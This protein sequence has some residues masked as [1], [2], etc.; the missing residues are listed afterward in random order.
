[1]FDRANHVRGVVLVSAA[2]CYLAAS[3]F[4]DVSGTHPTSSKA[5]TVTA[6]VPAFDQAQINRLIKQL[7]SDKFEDHEA[8]QTALVEIGLPARRALQSAASASDV[9]VARRA[10]QSLED[11]ARVALDDLAKRLSEATANTW[12]INRKERAAGL[13]PE[14]GAN[15]TTWYGLASPYIIFPFPQDQDGQ[16][17]VALFLKNVNVRF[18]TIADDDNWTVLATDSREPA[19]TDKILT[20]MGLTERQSAR[21]QRLRQSSANV[22]DLRLAVAKPGDDK[23]DRP[24]PLADGPSTAQVEEYKRLFADK[25]PNGGRH[26]G[27]SF[28]W[29]W[30]PDYCKVSPRLERTSDRGTE[31]LLLSD[32]PKERLLRGSARLDWGLTAVNFV[33]NAQGRP[34]VVLR[35]DKTASAALEK[36]TKDNPNRP[37]AVLF[38]GSVFAVVTIT[39][40]IS[41]RLELTWEGLDQDLAARIVTSLSECMLAQ[42]ASAAASLPASRGVPTT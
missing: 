29:F 27:D 28:L 18:D 11:I 4:A 21:Q 6:N 23:S 1:M 12:R 34:T 10:K 24:Q 9:E 2:L 25:G 20:S 37:L 22:L 41:H 13:G 3:I 39:Q 7:G 42:P 35:L 30:R 40:P 33:V 5:H 8:A 19:I 15:F 14:S 26:R 32:R 36:L 31:Y 38:N 17:K 16:A